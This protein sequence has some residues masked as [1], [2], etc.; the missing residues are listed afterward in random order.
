MDTNTHNGT[1]PHRFIFVGG[2]ARSGT[3][4]LQKMLC[5]HSRICGGPEFDHAVPAMQLFSRMTSPL[6]LERQQFYYDEQQVTDCF[7]EF[8]ASLFDSLAQRNPNIAYISEKTPANIAAAPELLRLFPDAFYINIVR[9]GRDVVLSYQKVLKRF[10]QEHGNKGKRWWHEYTVR[11]VSRTWNA[12]IDRYV[13]MSAI[14]SIAPRVLNVQYEQ[15][16]A[17]PKAVLVPILEKLGLELEPQ[18]LEPDSVDKEQLG[19]SANLDNVWY[20]EQQFNQKLNSGSVGKWKTDLPFFKRALTN[21]WQCRNL[22]RMGY[23]VSPRTLKLRNA[24]DRLRGRKVEE[25]S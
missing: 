3:T 11:N 12:D 24:I 14:E 4:L 6:Q 18:L 23:A 20:T 25:S 22:K 8:Y 9:D 7:R 2:S 10:Q 13:S 19:Y 5:A 21:F 15:I 17:D 1:R 16:V